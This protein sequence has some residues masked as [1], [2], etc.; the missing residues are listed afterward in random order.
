MTTINLITCNSTKVIS[1]V[2]LI[3]FWKY[4]A[5]DNCPLR[6]VLGFTFTISCQKFVFGRILTSEGLT[7][8][9]PFFFS[10]A[11]QLQ[12]YRW[13]HCCIAKQLLPLS[14]YLSI[15]LKNQTTGHMS[16]WSAACSGWRYLPDIIKNYGF[17]FLKNTSHVHVYIYIYI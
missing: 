5:T 15:N 1:N 14:A 16:V 9:R 8:F 4:F 7:D 10:Q 11:I 12:I 13:R 17:L 3:Y 2:Y 6:N